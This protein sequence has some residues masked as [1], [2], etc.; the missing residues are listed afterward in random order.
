MTRIG[1]SVAA[2][3]LLLLANCAHGDGAATLFGAYSARGPAMD[4]MPGV[5]LEI[6]RP[7]RYRFCAAGRCDAGKW[8]IQ[9]E[10]ACG[11]RITLFGPAPEALVRSLAIA[12]VG[13]DPMWE[14]RGTQNE[15]DL[16]YRACRGATEIVLGT[17]DAAFVKR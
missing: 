5:T 12:A 6:A 2:L 1:M 9:P 13:R 17:G 7:D 11:G 10:G 3:A 4:A 8:A 15:I 16:D 14:Q